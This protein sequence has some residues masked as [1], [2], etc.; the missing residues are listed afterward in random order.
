MSVE[1]WYIAGLLVFIFA[2]K[3]RIDRQDK[4][5]RHQRYLDRLYDSEI[6]M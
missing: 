1:L 6:G 5:Y 4:H 2:C 3:A